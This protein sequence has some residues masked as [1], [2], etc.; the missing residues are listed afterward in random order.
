MLWSVTRRGES[1]VIPILVRPVDNWQSEA[2]AQLQVLPTD[3]RFLTEWENQDAALANVAA[4]IRRALEDL[5]VQP[6]SALQMGLPSVWNVPYPRNLLFTGREALL[7]QL[8]T[9]LSTGEPTAL[10]QPQA[11]SGLGGIGKTQLALEYAYKYRQDYQAV[12]WIQAD[13]RENLTTSYLTLA[14]L[15]SLPEKNLSEAD[16]VIEAVKLWLHTH[17]SYLLILD[18]ADELKLVRDFLPPSFGGHLLLTTRAQATGRLARR[19]EVDILPQELGALFL[20]RRSGLL[21]PHLSLEQASEGDQGLGRAIC[22]ELGGLP[23]ALDQAGAYIEETG[24]SLAEYQRLY[25]SQRSDLL[26]ERRGLIDDHPHPVATTWNLSFERVQG[27]N[28]AAADLLRLC[29]F[30]APDAIPSEFIT[31]GEPSLGPD[32][33]SVSGDEYLLNQAIEAL[34]A[35]SLVSREASHGTGSTLSVHRLVQAVLQDM[36]TAKVCR[37]WAER[38]VRTVN[39]MFPRVDYSSWKQAQPYLSHVEVSASLIERY[40]FAFP[41]AGALLYAYGRYLYFTAQYE[42]AEPFY[43]Q[44]LHIF[45]E[46]LG[47]E[48]PNTAATL[49]ELARLFQMQ[50]KY[51]HA[52]SIY[53]RALHIYE[54][55]L[56]PEHPS[57]AA[58]LQEL[59]GLFQLQG[60][61]EQAIPL[62]LSTLRMREEALG[63]LHPDT[64]TTLLELGKLFQAQGEYEQAELFY[65]RALRINEQML[66]SQHPDTAATL[67]ELGKLFQAQGKY[68]QAELRYQRALRIREEALGS[69]HPS[70]ATSIHELARLAQKLGKYE[71]A[72][73]RYQQAL[74]IRE[75]Q[76]RIP[77]PRHSYQS[78]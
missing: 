40:T 41:E 5:P 71:Q 6:T 28:P 21:P 30:L 73:L 49:K 77:T 25:Q 67:Q 62:Y 43:Q 23:L 13:T 10:G 7:E 53:Q 27:T 1:R 57:T 19:L 64:A 58:T 12:L 34:L 46:E 37:Q 29:A 36:M 32:L 70:T 8:V 61:Y 68:K 66:E 17:T 69:E 76:F 20:L 60:K 74:S 2:F 11:I 26:A 48:H 47:P 38:A 16:V 33:A 51:A 75:Q 4:G 3:A 45:E 50:G 35:Y 52:E 55:V 39:A 42:Q 65:Q 14:R 59:A 31:Y 9:N 24:C 54:R 56:G 15:L 63:P 44:A 72:E 18:N 78:E 22:D